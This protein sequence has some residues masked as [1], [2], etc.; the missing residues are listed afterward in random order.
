MVV[1]IVT[2][3]GS[4]DTVFSIVTVEVGGQL[5]VASSGPVVRWWGEKLPDISPDG[6]AVPYAAVGP[7]VAVEL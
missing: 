7:E 1:V 4:A 2:V 6:P 5:H 3:N